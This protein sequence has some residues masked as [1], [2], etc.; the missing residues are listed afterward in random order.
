MSEIREHPISLDLFIVVDKL[1][2]LASSGSLRSLISAIVNNELCNRHTLLCMLI[3]MYNTICYIH[4]L[5]E[6]KLVK[7]LTC[8]EPRLTI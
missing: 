8:Y 4:M 7:G 5:E 2:G 6:K 1:E 3:V